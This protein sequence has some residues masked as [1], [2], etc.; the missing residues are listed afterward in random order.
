MDLVIGQSQM[1]TKVCRSCQQEY[2]ATSEHFYKLNNSFHLDCKSCYKLRR[3]DYRSKQ[4]PVHTGEIVAINR[5][6]AEGIFATSGKSS[7]WGKYIDVVCWGCVKVEVKHSVES[8][9]GSWTWILT[10]TN[11]P[12]TPSPDFILLIGQHKDGTHSYFFF[13]VNHPV[14]FKDGRRKTG[15]TYMAESKQRNNRH[16]YLVLTPQIMRD[17]QNAF[18]QIETLRL[19]KIKQFR[20]EYNQTEHLGKAA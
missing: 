13:P 4:E 18:H 11:N 9:R 10:S 5:L 19:D 14:F 12:D 8:K 20:E 2:P 1:D 15:I 3:K 7:V 16:D 17:Y 6:L